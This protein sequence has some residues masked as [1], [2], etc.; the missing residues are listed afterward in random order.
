MKRLEEEVEGSIVAM[1]KRDIQNAAGVKSSISFGLDPDLPPPPP[2]LHLE[3]NAASSCGTPLP[4]PPPP[5]FLKHPR[6]RSEVLDTGVVGD[7][8]ERYVLVCD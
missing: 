3:D 5:M 2:P 1:W 8:A 7:S 6:P 4:P